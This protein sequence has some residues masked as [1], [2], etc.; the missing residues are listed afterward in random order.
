LKNF[1][2]YKKTYFFVFFLKKI[3]ETH[4]TDFSNWHLLLTYNFCNF[5]SL[6]KLHHF[7]CIRENILWNQKLLHRFNFLWLFLLLNIKKLKTQTR[8]ELIKMFSLRVWFSKNRSKLIVPIK[9]RFLVWY[10]I[11]QNAD[12][13]IIFSIKRRFAFE[14]NKRLSPSFRLFFLNIFSFW[15]EWDFFQIRMNFILHTF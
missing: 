11:T 8:Y 14:I 1:K 5:W 7:H 2:I 6:T 13:F 10:E 4:S 15:G 9:Y 3:I 12:F